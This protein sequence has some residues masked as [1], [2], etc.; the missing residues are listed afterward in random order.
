MNIKKLFLQDLNCADCAYK[1]EKDINNINNVKSANLNFSNSTITVDIK[2]KEDWEY[3]YK[4]IK[5][6]VNKYEP[7]V[8]IIE[9][10]E[11]IH[12]LHHHNFIEKGYSKERVFI[13]FGII[14]FSISLIFTFNFPVNLILFIV[15]YLLIGGKIL[16]RAIKNIFRGQIFDENFLMSIATLGAFA[17][18]EYP[19]AVAVMLFYQIGEFFQD[20]AV[21]KSRKSIHDL[22][23]IRPDYANLKINEKITRIQPQN[24]NIGDIIII[25]PGE[26]V[27]LDGKVLDGESMMDTSALTG[28]S[29][30]LKVRTGDEVL[31]GFINN[32]GLITLEVTKSFG[33]STVSK[34]LDLVENASS[35]KASTE[36]FITKFSRY[37]TPIVVYAAMALAIIPPIVIGTG[38]SQWIYRALIFLVISC[39]CALV[40]S[41]PLGFFGGI[42]AASKNGILVKG[43]NYLEAL[44][45]IDMIVFDK[46]GTLTRGTFEV[47]LIKPYGEFTKEQL[48]DYAA[49]GEF[50]SNHPIATSILKKY[51]GSINKEDILEYNE[52][53]GY[54]IKA[55]VRG[56][57][58]LLGNNKLM[59]KENIKYSPSL[60]IGTIVH[61]AVEKQYLGYLVISDEIKA[62]TKDTIKSLKSLGIRKSIMLTGDNKMIGESIAKEINLDEF[63]AQ[64]L[65]QEKV[66]KLEALELE[67]L[68]GKKLAFVGDGINDAPVLARADIGIAMGGLGSDAAIE[69]A[70]V[71]LMTDEPSKIIKAINIAKFTRSIVIQNIIFALT[72]KIIV[73]LLGAL[74]IATMWSA[75]FADVGVSLIAVLNTLRVLNSN[76]V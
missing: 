29:K 53:P 12:S 23:D 48:L 66:E 63:Y 74:G 20:M 18:G 64:L 17:I 27:P 71:V 67:K 16:L 55:I 30:P 58:I 5:E 52:L 69:A 22:M 70:D 21:D 62:D 45:N 51:D 3:V 7:D 35:N 75:V 32:N 43:G 26:K 2:T 10:I 59:N 8:K 68:K 6:I 31:S 60:E 33:E 39:P 47:V 73:L 24:V 65:P 41:I 1:I 34:I 42:G 25:K 46:T 19:E 56:K 37:Y 76:G 57:E 36:Q 72:I 9:N 38:F 13:L 44:N 49:Y 15:G 54:G 4:N 61:V 14:I 28:E 50:Y 11:D 40:I